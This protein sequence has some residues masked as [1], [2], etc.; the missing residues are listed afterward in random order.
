MSESST[1]K[2]LQPSRQGSK[3]PWLRVK[4]PVRAQRS[5]TS[6]IVHNHGLHTICEEARC[7]NISECW[8]HGTATFLL[9]G[10]TCTRSCRFC[11]VRSVAPKPLDPTEPERIAQA[12]REMELKSV[13]LTSVTRDDLPDGGAMQFYMTVQAVKE[14][15]PD[16]A[17]EILI[18]D[19]QGD[20]K[21][22]ETVL[23]AEISVLSHNVETVPRLYKTVR[24][25][26]DYHRSLELLQRAARAYPDLA[27]KSGIM[28]GLGEEQSEV[29]DVMKDLREAGCSI[30]TI[31]Q[32]LRPSPHYHPVIRY[33]HPDEFE[34]YS[35]CG[36]ELGFRHVESAPLVR[37]SYHA[38]KHV[39]GSVK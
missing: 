26:A 24:P 15:S 21:A 33:V 7:P 6:A 9:L 3:P 34:T 32:Y 27:V 5:S 38:W 14:R 8:N 11:A 1:Q 4:A 17:V 2:R 36:K 19:F 10:D 28:V 13:V 35:R 30:V 12:V 37:S 16:C 31:G 20:Q 23:K 29:F 39:E 18:P 22:L 25:Q